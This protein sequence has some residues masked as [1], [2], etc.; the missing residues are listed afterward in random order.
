[1]NDIKLTDDGDIEVSKLGDIS[2]CDNIVQD[3]K[4]K[5]QWIYGEWKF[6]PENG[7]D[8]FGNILVKNP[9]FDNIRDMIRSEIMD[10]EGVSS[11]DITEVNYYNEKRIFNVKFKI[12]TTDN[13]QEEGEVSFNG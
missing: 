6:A 3:I 8:Y 9:N 13:I 10:V 11:V 7:V 1:M 4:I 5:L 2:I 12:Y